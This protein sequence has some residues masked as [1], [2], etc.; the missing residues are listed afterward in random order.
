MFL[1]RQTGLKGKEGNV[2]E[3][4]IAKRPRRLSPPRPAA[5]A[6]A[7][8]HARP[9]HDAV[10]AALSLRRPPHEPCPLLCP[11]SSPASSLL[12]L[13]EPETLAGEDHRIP[14]LWSSPS[15]S[16]W[17]KSTAS[18]CCVSPQKESGRE[19]A[20]RRRHLLLLCGRP[21]EFEHRA[22]AVLHHRTHHLPAK[23]MH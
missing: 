7:P 9:P 11:S 13:C 19:A 10:P 6:M 5:T 8:R 22:A 18:P 14:P 2:A 20:N 16:E 15:T 1:L 12:F 17:G 4:V 23:A 3:G 21:T